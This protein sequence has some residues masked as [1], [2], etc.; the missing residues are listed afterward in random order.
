[1]VPKRLVI[2]GSTGSIGRSCLDV[3]SRHPG[4][5]IVRALAAHSNAELLAEQYRAVKPDYLCLVDGT[6]AAELRSRLSGEPVEILVGED[7]LI[8]LATLDNTDTVVN[9][10][11]GAAGLMASLETVKSGRPLALANKE[12]LVCGGPLFSRLMKKSGAKILPIDSE[13]S[14]IWQALA[15]G[16]ESELRR[17]IITASGGPF[18]NLPLE[19]FQS[20]TVEQALDHPTW[21]MGP[22]ITI[23]SATLVNKGLEVIEAVVLFS[24]PADK[25]SVVIHPQSIIHSMVEF[26]DSS[27]IA[28]LSKPD[29]RLPITY[30]LFWPD[31]V[32]SDFGSVDIE[33]LGQFTFEPPDLEKF[34]ALKLAYQVAATGGTA[35]AVF[36]AANE[37]AVNAFL[38]NALRFTQITDI[39]ENVVEKLEVVSQPELNDI[40]AADKK[41]RRMAKDMSGK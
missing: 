6:R 25:V 34:R 30:A 40:L 7:E 26:I 16:K 3:I 21:K 2:L 22:K 13:H 33:K 17:I 4:R 28:Q 5:F 24:I 12:S 27:V 19:K 23:D 20:I 9:A 38:N 31:R 35:P 18:R 15:C 41:A 8:R 10:V 1:M 37:V 14:A 36:N 29:M 39:I 11:V 32:E